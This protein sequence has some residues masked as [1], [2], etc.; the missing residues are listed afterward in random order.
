MSTRERLLASTLAELDD[1]GLRFVRISEVARQAGLTSGA[2]YGLFRT[3]RDLIAAALIQRN[4]GAIRDSLDRLPFGPD[5]VALLAHAFAALDEKGFRRAQLRDVA[6]R[7]GTTVQAIKARY[8]NKQI[9]LSTAFVAHDPEA[10][11]D[12]LADVDGTTPGTTADGS[13]RDRLL[14]ATL[15]LLDE[16]GV[17]ATVSGIAH[18]AGLTTGAVYSHFGSKE[19]LLA[20]ALQRR[21]EELLDT[22]LDQAHDVGTTNGLAR[23]LA[24]S[25]TASSDVSHRALVEVIALTNTDDDVRVALAAQLA[26]RQSLVAARLGAEQH[27]HTITEEVSI[28]A[29]AYVIQLLA[30]GNIVGHTIGLEQPNSQELTSLLE[31]LTS[32]LKPDPSAQATR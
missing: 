2:I 19:Q 16:H 4:S 9:L 18:R 21:Y 31:R 11:R 20:A 22:T 29:L 10:F 7:A 30:L 15:A 5:E 32:G 8:P 25:L 24:A 12:A 27:A 3:K 6:R 1:K 17:R 28:D 26:G 14:T 13:T 23:A